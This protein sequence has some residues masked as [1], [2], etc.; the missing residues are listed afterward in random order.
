MPFG[1]SVMSTVIWLTDSTDANVMQAVEII[2]ALL[3]VGLIVS[4]SYWV[5]AYAQRHL[6]VLIKQ[7]RLF[8]FRSVLIVL[9]GTIGVVF[10]S[11][12]WQ[13]STNETA[14][15]LPLPWTIWDNSNYFWRG[16][17]NPLLVIA[18]AADLFFGLALPHLPVAILC[19]IKR[20]RLRRVSIGAK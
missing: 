11:I 17:M 20:R 9:A 18:W 13:L 1:G 8:I 10:A 6:R 16:S 14:V 12:S 7:E 5:I 19:C 2:G 3:F 15:G 4:S